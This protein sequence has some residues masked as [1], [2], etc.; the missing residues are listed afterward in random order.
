MYRKYYLVILLLIAA[1]GG[2]AS[3]EKLLPKV[4]D[5]DQLLDG[6]VDGLT[7][8]QNKRFL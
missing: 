5:D 1:I 6:P 7:P 2:L 3:C 4:E 8:E